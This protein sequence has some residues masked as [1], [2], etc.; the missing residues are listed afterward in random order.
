[1]GCF[2]HQSYS[3]EG[4][5]FLGNSP[6]RGYTW[7]IPFFLPLLEEF[8]HKVVVEVL[9]YVLEVGYVGNILEKLFS[10]LWTGGLYWWLRILWAGAFR[11]YNLTEIVH[12]IGS[13]MQKHQPQKADYNYKLNSI[14]SLEVSM[15]IKHRIINLWR[16]QVR[17][18][19]P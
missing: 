19:S 4:S 5:G 15:V 6:W 16:F 10:Q 14:P 18:P 11:W 7:S 2:D 3:K 1:M 8:L 9:G 17:A 13:R 12:V